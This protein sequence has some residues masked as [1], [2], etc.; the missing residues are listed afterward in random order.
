M[1]KLDET[2]MLRLL[3]QDAIAIWTKKNLFIPLNLRPAHSFIGGMTAA[4]TPI[5]CSLQNKDIVICDVDRPSQISRPVYVCPCSRK[6]F[7]II[8]AFVS[9]DHGYCLVVLSR[10][11][12]FTFIAA[13]YLRTNHQN[14]YI[15]A[16]N[17][18]ER[19]Y[20]LSSLGTINPKDN[21][22]VIKRCQSEQ[23][24]GCVG[25]HWE[26]VRNT[27]IFL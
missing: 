17:N 25:S 7:S 13:D 1:Y 2:E 18:A 3:E 26:E 16:F 5:D 10:K 27:T 11:Y 6:L 21:Q 22:D 9:P 8:Y 12:I 19:K 14:L 4:T 15:R 20:F 23:C 24:D